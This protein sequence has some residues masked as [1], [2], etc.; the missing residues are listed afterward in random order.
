[1]KNFISPITLILGFSLI[2]AGCSQDSDTK[3][4]RKGGGSDLSSQNPI[5]SQVIYGEDNRL[6]LYDVESDL[7]HNLAQ[8]TA[9]MM[10]AA[11]LTPDSD[12]V[13]VRGVKLKDSFDFPL[14]SSE[15]FKEQYTA[16]YCTAFLVAPKLVATAGHCFLNK[17]ECKVAR[18]VFGYGL[19]EPAQ[20]LTRVPAKDVYACKKIL[21]LEEIRQG[22]DYAVVEL[23]RAVFDRKPLALR[24][25]GQLQ[26]GD[27]LVI[28]GHP[29]GLPTKVA[30]GAQVR[31]VVNSTH[32]VTN[33]DSYVGNSGSPIFNAKSGLVEGILVRGEGDYVYQNGCMRSKVCAP[34]ECRGED[35]TLI[36][37]V[38]NQ[39][40]YRPPMSK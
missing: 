31:T 18:F 40:S 34:K 25:E 8:S 26:A 14:C 29:T 36:S 2:L 16:S 38:V 21:K 7:Y 27:E 3:K 1:M 33:T 35:A 24:Q 23:D 10:F 9:A 4:K 20:D 12:S 22:Q 11:D 30:A 6:D 5:K 15:R 17:E 39:V 28:I 32:F 37:W 13:R 19:Q